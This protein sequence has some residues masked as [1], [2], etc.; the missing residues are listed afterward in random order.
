MAWF[1]SIL[2]LSTYLHVSSSLLLHYLNGTY[3]TLP[4]MY[5]TLGKAPINNQIF[6]NFTVL[7]SSELNSRECV[8]YTNVTQA[9]V[10]YGHPTSPAM[11]GCCT[12]TAF[13]SDTAFARTLER[14]GASGLLLAAKEQ[15]YFSKLL[16]SV[17]YFRNTHVNIFFFLNMNNA[18]SMQEEEL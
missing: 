16:V 9:F 5:S 1:L 10:I 17:E 18:C 12:D 3:L 14:Y 2:V 7:S 13:G 6:P 15:V 4:S 11:S 8:I